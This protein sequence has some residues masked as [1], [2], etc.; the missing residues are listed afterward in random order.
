MHSERYRRQSLVKYYK[1]ITGANLIAFIDGIYADCLVTLEDLLYDCEPDRELHVLLASPGGDGET[2]LKIIRLM[3]SHCSKL[4]VIVPDMA[5]SAATIICLGADEILMGPAG[6]LGPIDPQML[7]GGGRG[8]VSAKEIV[9]ALDEA[10]KRVNA[11]P[12]SFPLFSSLLS[13]VNMLMVEQAR[14]ALDRSESL[15]REA[16]SS[17]SRRSDDEVDQ[18]A[19][20]LKAPLIDEPSM[21][22]AVFSAE[23]AASHGLPA[24]NADVQSEQW[25]TVWALWTS[26]CALG[27]FPVGKTSVY[28]GIRASNVRSPQ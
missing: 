9:A 3:H 10:E 16:L 26:Y 6:D 17:L 4:T 28:E 12:N 2:A 5:K 21:H 19:S 22:S 18:L 1:D 27:C 14:S 23:D 20:Q 25:K 7:L 15:M 11:N 13:D 8:A 24:I